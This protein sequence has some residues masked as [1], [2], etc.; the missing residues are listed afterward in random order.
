MKL[1]SL[2]LVGVLLGG[3]VSESKY[4]VT[5]HYD[6]ERFY[7]AGLS[8]D[9]SFWSVI[10]WSVSRP[11]AQYPEWIENKFKPELPTIL[12][13]GKVATTFINH[14]TFLL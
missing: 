14:A 1:F 3:C 10:K 6:G 4:P 7:H 12:P 2:I 11:D 5:D 8:I 13:V 9:K